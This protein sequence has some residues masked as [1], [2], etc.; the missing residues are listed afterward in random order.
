MF[1]IFALAKIIAVP[2]TMLFFGM[3]LL[4]DDT[5][6]LVVGTVT[7]LGG[8]VMLFFSPR[9]AA[10]LLAVGA[11]LIALGFRTRRRIERDL[12]MEAEQASRAVA[13]VNRL[14]LPPNDRDRN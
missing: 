3:I 8:F 14:Y 12:E 1:T 9:S 13:R 11:G 4:P 10:V 6:F 5:Y 7:I 2:F